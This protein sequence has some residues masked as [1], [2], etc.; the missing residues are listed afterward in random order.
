MTAPPLPV[1]VSR[2]R[3]WAT[4]GLAAALAVSGA[5]AVAGPAGADDGPSVTATP[6]ADLPIDDASITVT[7]TGFATVGTGVYVGVGPAGVQSD[8]A[9]FS[10][11]SYFQGVKWVTTASIADGSFTQELTGIDAV[12]DSNG[13]EVDCRATECGIYTMAAHGVPDRS[14]DTYTPITFQADTPTW[15]P[16]ISVSKTTEL[17][18]TGETVT[19]TGTGFDP[20]ANIGTRQPF[21][22]QP[23][24]VYV[25][26]GKFADDWRP[27]QGALPDAREVISQK[28]ALP[29]PPTGPLYVELTAEGTFTAELDVSMD[30]AADGNYGVYTYAAGGPVNADQELYQPMTFA[31]ETP[32]T[33]TTTTPPT[34]TPEP[35]TSTTTDPGPTTTTPSGPLTVEGGYLDWGVKQSFRSYITGGIAKGSV[36]P[37]GGATANSDG[38]FRFPAAGGEVAPDG[39][40]LLAAFGGSVS[41]S[42]HEG[43]LDL[44]I[45]GLQV[46]VDGN[47]GALVA[48]IASTP[49]EAGAMTGAAVMAPAATEVYEDVVLATLDLTGSSPTRVATQV[50]WA[51]IA[52]TLTEAGVPAFSDFYQAGAEL[53]PLTVVLDLS[54]TADVPEGTPGGSGGSGGSGAGRGA[55]AVTPRG[56]LPYTG[57]DSSPLVLVAVALAVGGAGL[58]VVAARRRAVA[59]VTSEDR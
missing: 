14:Q 50:T 57:S 55:A 44:T 40:E 47:R 22:G 4:A 37:S 42:G 36:T 56:R 30:E 39:S 25:V 58:S 5:V 46:A 9:W 11:A 23:T 29:N 51:D 41:F 20:N 16:Q 27:S 24:G 15:N 2:P 53:D 10:N 49:L 48:D 19:V 1:R 26:F 34:T 21:P 31:G 32:E 59:T 38:T 35:T 6:I 33:T 45:S 43:A 17:A 12:F 13:T 28:W 8:P 7:G 18:R 3:K 54:A 52:A